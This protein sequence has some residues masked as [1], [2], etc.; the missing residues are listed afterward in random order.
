MSMM[1][2]D[3]SLVVSSILQYKNDRESQLQESPDPGAL[4]DAWQADVDSRVN[5]AVQTRLGGDDDLWNKKWGHL[6][7][8]D[9]QISILGRCLYQY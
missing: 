6:G 8:T 7:I 4:L 3:T 5:D 2:T 1:S 9:V